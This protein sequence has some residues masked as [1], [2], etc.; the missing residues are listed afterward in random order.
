MAEDRL[1]RVRASIQFFS[2]V[3]IKPFKVAIG[4]GVTDNISLIGLT[5]NR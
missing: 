4:V 1:G 5:Q 3:I 2:A